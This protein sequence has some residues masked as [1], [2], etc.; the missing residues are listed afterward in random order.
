[1]EAEISRHAKARESGLRTILFVCT[2]N[3]VRSQIAEGIVNH[4][5]RET[6]AAFSA[7]VMP[8][9]LNKGVVKVMQEIGIDVSGQ[10]A[11]HVDLFKDCAFD[12]VVILCSDAG[13]FCPNLPDYRK[14]DHLIFHDPISM[15]G[16]HFGSK[17]LLRKLRDEMRERL[18]GYLN[19]E[20]P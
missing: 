7:G 20:G 1:M 16:L 13:R 14:K 5:F 2:G 3:A 18:A 6:W 4:A 15:A 9:E 11:K 17:S 10:K 19:T 12:R 8:M